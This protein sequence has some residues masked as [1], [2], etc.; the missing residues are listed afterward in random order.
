[1]A[2]DF[3][4]SYTGAEI[5]RRLGLVQE[6]NAKIAAMPEY[7]QS[8]NGILPDESGNVTVT[9]TAQQPEFVIKD[10]LEEALQ[11]LAENGDTSKV[12]VL[13]DGYMYS[14]MTKTLEREIPNCTNLFKVSEAKDGY[15]ISSNGS[16]KEQSG[17]NS[18]VSNFI[19]VEPNTEYALRACP[20]F[21]MIGEY[22]DLPTN[23]QIAVVPD[24]AVKNYDPDNKI[25]EPPRSG[26][27][28]S[29]ITTSATTKYIRLTIYRNNTVFIY[30][31][32]YYITLNEPVDFGSK[33]VTQTVTEWM[34]TG[35]SFVSTDYGD[36]ILAIEED[37]LDHET[38]LSILEKGKVND[39]PTYWQAHLDER[40]SAIREIMS[41]V[42]KNK[43]AFY[44]YSDA[45][46]NSNA[47]KSPVL[48]KHLYKYTPINKIN[49][50]GDIVATESYDF[51]DM[52]YLFDNWRSAIRDL[53]N[54][55]SV[56]G[57]HDDRNEQGYDHGFSKQYVYS[58]LLAP[59]ETN[60]RVDGAE[61][62]Y[63]IDDKCENT[64][65]LYLDTACYDG[66]A[67]SVE[68]AQFVAN[69]LKSTPDNYHIV[70]IAHAWYNQDYTNYPAVTV[71]GLTAVTSKLIELFSAYNNKATG[72]LTSLASS[73]AITYDFSNA[74]AKVEFC[75]GGHLH[76]DYAQVFNGIPV[77]LCEA[78]T[79]H[80]RNGSVAKVGT[81]SEQAITAVIADYINSTIN[82]IRIGRGSSRI[83]NITNGE[84]TKYYF[85]KLITAGYEIGRLNSAGTT[86]DRDDRVVTGFIQAKT[87][88]TI[89]FKNIATQKSDYGCNVAHYGNNKVFKEGTSYNLGDS[90][91]GVTWNSD[92]SIKSY[93]IGISGVE[94][95]R[96][97]FVNIDDTSLITVNEPIE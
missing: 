54:H 63:Y 34:N 28:L 2:V 20:G 58:F 55:H 72:T 83:V 11:W 81:T 27:R 75:I 35:Q 87:G 13:P 49:Y 95:L 74:G 62:Y 38:R 36:R 14:Y 31:D 24:T 32:E 57:N 86:T 46:W 22:S 70:V 50:G 69:A 91:G 93:T 77:I 12:Y 51:S 25:W 59:E 88:D 45:H 82:L 79:I 15:R 18:V 90:S 5:N 4:L 48:L 44:F 1:M 41:T 23:E 71:S 84:I 85:N 33:V 56:A 26:V 21:G 66:Y 67:L 29:Y 39:I 73:G 9:V 97:C 43:S 94:W 52:A 92:G 8:V 53:P 40:V 80:N 16:L 76:N 89:Y 60:D 30:P 78:D 42:G 10:T 47:G 61:L 65:Y 19:K 7:V 37:V 96:F 17:T 3:Q 64:R 68:Q 6:L